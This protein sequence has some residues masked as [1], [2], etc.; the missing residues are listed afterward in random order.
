MPFS[1]SANWLRDQ[2]IDLLSPGCFAVLRA[3]PIPQHI[4]FVMDGNRRHARING[5]K[6]LQGHVD[7]VVALKKVF[8]TPYEHSYNALMSSTLLDSGNKFYP[9]DQIHLCICLR[10][11]QLQAP[12][13]RGRRTD[14]FGQDGASGPLLTWVRRSSVLSHD[15]VLAY[16]LRTPRGLFDQYSVRLNP[17]GQTDLF[18]P[19]VQAALAKA[20]EMTTDNERWVRACEMPFYPPH[21]DIF[22]EQC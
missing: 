4:A 5:M 8:R 16:W 6:V 10:H 7:G 19:E 13:R 21:M 15:S 2:A 22:I 17:I 1:S 9:R 3:G 18:P 12:G 20:R 14:A 11:R